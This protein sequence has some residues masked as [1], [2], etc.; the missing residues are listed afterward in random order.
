MVAGP[1]AHLP[2]AL[3]HSWTVKHQCVN[4][5]AEGLWEELLDDEQ[6]DITV[7]DWYVPLPYQVPKAPDPLCAPLWSELPTRTLQ[8]CPPLWP[9][10]SDTFSFGDVPGPRLFLPPHMLAALCSRDKFLLIL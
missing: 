10:L 3:S 2:C 8:P 9:L 7:M 6:P 4:L 5:L 1:R